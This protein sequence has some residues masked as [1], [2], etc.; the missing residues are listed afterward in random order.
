MIVEPMADDKLEERSPAPAVN[1]LI[2]PK[3]GPN[4]GILHSMLN[5][6]H[7]WHSKLYCRGGTRR[8]V[9]ARMSLQDRGQPNTFDLFWWQT[10]IQLVLDPR[11][12]VRRNRSPSQVSVCDPPRYAWQR[13]V[14]A[15]QSATS[16]LCLCRVPGSYRSA[17]G[18][19][20]PRGPPKE[21]E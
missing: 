11:P 2:R 21:L 15:G 9:C 13:G 6:T 7:H 5:A 3:K 16:R 14:A 17:Y 8:V 20:R 10:G 18:I 1:W 12:N 19:R 4:A